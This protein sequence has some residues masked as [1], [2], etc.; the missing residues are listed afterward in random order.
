MYY[1]RVPVRDQARLP[2]F[3]SGLP[4]LNFAQIFTDNIYSGHDRIADASQVTLGVTSRL[5]GLDSA[6]EP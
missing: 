2:V 4:D 6:G 3:D 1:L 5:L